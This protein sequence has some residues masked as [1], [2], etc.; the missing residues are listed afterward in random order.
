MV[1][2]TA[3]ISLDTFCKVLAWVSKSQRFRVLRLGAFKDTNLLAKACNLEVVTT[4]ENGGLIFGSDNNFESDDTQSAIKDHQKD[5]VGGT[6]M[7]YYGFLRRHHFKSINQLLSLAVE[8]GFHA[9]DVH[10]KVDASDKVNSLANLLDRKIELQEPVSAST[11]QV[12]YTRLFDQS[13]Y[14]TG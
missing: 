2:K 7:N 14:S 4:D 10:S 12:F 6:L 3:Y 8:Y 11:I 13:G 5:E 9:T 1:R